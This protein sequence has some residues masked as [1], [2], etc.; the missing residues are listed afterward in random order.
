PLMPTGPLLRVAGC[1]RP[2][3]RCRGSAATAAAR[4]PPGAAPSA[5][6]GA[7]GTCR[8]PARPR[9][10]RASGAAS[11]CRS[12]APTPAPST[13]R[14]RAAQGGPTWGCA[15]SP[16]RC[17]GARACARAR[18]CAS[19]SARAG[20]PWRSPAPSP[21]GSCQT[22]A[23]WRRGCAAGWTL[24][25]ALARRPRCQTP[26]RSRRR[27]APTSC[28]ASRR[29]RGV[30]RGHCGRPCGPARPGTCTAAVAASP[31]CCWPRTACRWGRPAGSCGAARPSQAWWWSS[32]TTA[33][34]PR[35]RGAGVLRRGRGGRLGGAADLAGP[36]H[37]ACLA[38]DHG[39]NALPRRDAAQLRGRGPGGLRPAQGW[40]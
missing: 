27:G 35:R 20:T 34:T 23:A 2:P 31:C 40:L 38:R 15:A 12:R 11:W 1:R 8:A 36:G 24:C 30:P 26:P 16:R 33:A 28:G 25:C 4:T 19:A 14:T 22:R 9:T 6:A 37:A 5:H 3:P 39:A 13:P 29:G 21:A 17:S 7:S 18:R 32:G 10:C